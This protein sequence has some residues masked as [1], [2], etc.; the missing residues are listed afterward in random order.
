MRLLFRTARRLG[1]GSSDP[2]LDLVLP[3]RSS[4]SLRPLTDDEI[5]L[6][7]SCSLG[8]LTATRNAAAWALAEATATT[9]EIPAVRVADV[10]LS[11]GHVWLAGSSKRDARRAELTEWGRMQL[12]RHVRRLDMAD[13]SSPLIYRGDGSEESRQAS[14]CQAVAATLVRAGLGG[15]PDVRPGSVPAWAGAALF[16]RTGRIESVAKALGIRS[17]DRAAGA[18]AWDWAREGGQ[19]R[20]WRGC[21]PGSRRGHPSQPGTVHARRGDPRATP[22]WWQASALPDDHAGGV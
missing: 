5:L 11:A 4:L 15:E 1:L 2:T 12:T 9:A 16:A 3:P 18:I 21:P 17:L 19:P 6:C 22:R 20:R 14:A 10:D 7:R 8:S 13:G